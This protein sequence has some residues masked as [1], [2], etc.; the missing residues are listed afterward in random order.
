MPRF[1]RNY[2]HTKYFHIITQGINKSH[3][4][5]NEIDKK[6]Y[7]KIMYELRKE[8]SI[9]IIAY[10]IMDN[11][12]HM[13]LEAEKIEDLSKYMHKLN[14]KYGKYYNRVHKRVGYVFRDRY[15]SEG[16]YGEEQL[17]NCINYI[18]NNPVKAKICN[19][20]EK[21]KYSN[22]IKMH[23]INKEVEYN[24]IDYNDIGEEDKLERYLLD[25]KIS[26]ENIIKN[27]SELKKMI[28]ELKENEGTSLRKIAEKFNINREMVRKIYKSH[29][30]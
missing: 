5:K 28:I 4:F 18:Y 23:S 1:P 12:M 26:I 21:Y 22:Y 15:K 30:K 10:C 25:N 3:I 19:S 13:L 17:Y 9:T 2:L 20:P 29:V 7:I 14:T 6:Y 11:H 24:F 27:K 16:I 8:Y